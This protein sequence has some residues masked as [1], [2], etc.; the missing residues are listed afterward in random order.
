VADPGVVAPLREVSEAV[1]RGVVDFVVA[2]PGMAGSGVNV[3]VGVGKSTTG[4]TFLVRLIQLMMESFVFKSLPKLF[5]I[6]VGARWD[7]QVAK[8]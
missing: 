6:G 8:C 2:A 3:L 7:A 4:S 5:C 1:A